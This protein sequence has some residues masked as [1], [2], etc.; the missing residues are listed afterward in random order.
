MEVFETFAP[1]VAYGLFGLLEVF[2]GYRLFRVLVVLLGVLTGL[3]FGPQ[4]YATLVGGTVD[5]TMASLLV[6]F[7][8]GRGVWGPG[9]LRLWGGRLL[10]GRPGRLHGG[11]RLPRRPALPA[12]GRGRV[13]PA[14]RPA[15]TASHHPSDEPPW[16]LAGV[17]R[18]L[19][20]RESRYG[21]HTAS[22]CLAGASPTL[23]DQP[24][25][26]V[27]GVFLALAGIIVQRA[28]PSRMEGIGRHRQRR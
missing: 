9:V 26:L 24:L 25:L 3:T 27:A 8:C 4:V 1:I 2:A 6:K 11:R 28:T 13:R 14:G 19:G 18:H 5:N 20:A 12:R 10:V 23:S 7:H 22:C 15:G 21:H 17:G 16:G